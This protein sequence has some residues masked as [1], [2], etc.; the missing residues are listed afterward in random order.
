[1]RIKNI[2]LILML[3]LVVGH[4]EAQTFRGGVV[5]G[6]NASQINGD[7]IAGFNKIGLHLGLKVVSDITDKI[8]W[9]TELL[10]SERGSHTQAKFS[11]PFTISINYVEIPLLI[12]FKDWQQEDYYKMHFEAGASL[13]RII[14]Q[15]VKDIG[16]NTDIDGL[17]ETD[18]SA[19]VGAT[20]YSNDHLGFSA[21]YTHSINLL[22]DE[23]KH[24]GLSRFRGYF[25]TFRVLYLF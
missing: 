7:L 12:S 13:G 9:S 16:G 21:R 1:M 6:A 20:L 11:D 10:Y 5:L 22:R 8:A 19:I 4:L 24:P 17:N 14:D 3:S 25:L 23:R 15:K 18:L 2:Y